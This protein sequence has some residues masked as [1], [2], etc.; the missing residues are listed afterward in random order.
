[1]SVCSRSTALSRASDF[2]GLM[3]GITNPAELFY[4]CSVPRAS[5]IDALSARAATFALSQPADA[6]ASLCVVPGDQCGFE[7]RGTHARAVLASD[8][9]Q[10]RVAWIFFILAAVVVIA[11]LL[12]RR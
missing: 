12:L 11:L 2:L 3:E 7:I 5:D 4:S 8:G 9:Q 6:V 10:S 1:M